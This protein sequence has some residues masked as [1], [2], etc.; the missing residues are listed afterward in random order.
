MRLNPRLFLLG[1]VLAW[2][3][4]CV[5]FAAW[6]IGNERSRTRDDFTT[7]ARIAYSILTQRAEQQEAVLASLVA[8]EHAMPGNAPVMSN[9]ALSIQHGYP[10]LV[11]VERYGREDTGWR[12]FSTNGG[13]A[14]PSRQLDAAADQPGGTAGTQVAVL[15]DGY[16]LFRAAGHD[17]VFAL[18]VSAP[19]LAELAQSGAPSFQSVQMRTADGR[20]LWRYEH[21]AAWSPWPALQ[22]EKQLNTRGQPF[23][24]TATHAPLGAGVPWGRLVLGWSILG[25]AA[26]L[27]AWS[28][29]QYRS[30]TLA[31]RQLRLAQATRINAMGEVAAGIAHELNQPLTAVLANT[32]ASVRWLEDDPPDLVRAREAASGAVQQ[33]RRAGAILKRLREFISPHTGA[34]EAVD[35]NRVVDDALSLMSETFRQRQIRVVRNM[36]PN[37]PTVAGSAVAFE[38]VIVNLLLNAADALL[39]VPAPQRA[40][41]I[42]STLDGPQVVVVVRDSGGGLNAEALAR[43]FEPFYTTKEGGMGLGLTICE[44]I[45]HEAGGTLGAANVDAGAAFTLRLPVGAAT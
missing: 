17:V 7:Q 11:S 12:M 21:P 42:D 10:Q 18:R 36:A 28:M 23:V 40:L 33:A 35:L 6:L 15:D 3:A 4:C 43:V 1:S 27:A 30:R 38:Q 2:L 45:I 24:M 20:T 26:A 37:L 32:Q 29:A 31:Q 9:F 22:L 44:S 13:A 8:L 19:A 5:L 14:A 39:H 34:A 25:A 16:R 41:H